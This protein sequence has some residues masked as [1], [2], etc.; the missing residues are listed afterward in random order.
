MDTELKIQIIILIILLLLS[1]FFSSAETALV[2]VNRIKIRTLDEQGNKRAKTL[3]KIYEDEAKMLSAILIGNNLVNTYAASIAATIAYSFGGAVVSLATFLITLFILIFG[4]ITP[5]TM[6][7]QNAEDIALSYAPIILF[8]MKILT[9]FIFCINGLSHIVLHILGANMNN[10]NPSMTET[11]LRT[12]MDVS[13]EEGV[14][15]EDE[16]NLIN[17]VFDFSDA[18]ARDV[19]VPR[20]HVVM[21]D[22][23]STYQDLLE[24][25]RQDKFTRIPI[26]KESMDNIVGLV[27]MKDL[28]LYENLE[29]FDIN[30]VLRKPYFTYENKKISE[31]LVEM[32][33]STFNLS[34]VVDEYGELAGI[35]TL[36]DIIEEIVGDVHD[37]YDE[38]EQQ[39]IKKIND[40]TYDVKGYINLHDLNDALGLDLDNEDFDSIG[41]L[42]IDA[43]GCFPKQYDTVTL[44]NGIKIKV[45]SLEK[46]RIEEVRLYLPEKVEKE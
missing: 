9:P 45:I 27:N 1:S 36:E 12:M 10:N 5:K 23:D 15:E 28:L 42:V 29:D 17:N 24:I 16:K 41:G 18:K 4:E 2:S 25:F 14:I 39:N 8:L 26:Y 33:E 22:I 34:I 6:A 20:V 31:L 37:E 44:E 38:E 43:L 3:L 46:N 21:A 32:K 13:H 30:K 40:V 19:M 35:V 7:T 11:E